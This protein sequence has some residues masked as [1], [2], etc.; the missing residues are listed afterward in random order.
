[1]LVAIA[2]VAGIVAW[3]FVPGIPTKQPE[4]QDQ[5][6]STDVSTADWSTCRNEKYGYEF[7]YPNGWYVYGIITGSHDE[8]PELTDVCKTPHIVISQY[9]TMNGGFMPPYLHINVTT[10]DVWESLKETSEKFITKERMVGAEKVR[11]FIQAGFSSAVFFRDGK[12]FIFGLRN[13]HIA[14][15]TFFD[16]DL[17]TDVLWQKRLDAVISTF[18]FID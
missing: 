11:Y 8:Y 14:G 15:Q 3:R 10:V 1:M 9:P 16:S 18:K 17:S 5:A 7:K 2:V 13:K 12:A 4:L 6:T